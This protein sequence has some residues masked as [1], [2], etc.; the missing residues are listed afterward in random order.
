MK[1]AKEPSSGTKIL[2]TPKARGICYCCDKEMVAKCGEIKIHHWAHKNLEEC[3]HWWEN[4]T[5]WHRQWKDWFPLDWQEVV[6]RDA[7]SGEKHIADVYNP[8]KDLTI[9][10]QNSPIK[11]EEI[12]AREKYYK[13][14][15]W[16]LNGSE[17]SF[18]TMPIDGS[19]ADFAR[20]EARVKAKFR[21]IYREKKIEIEEQVRLVRK[22]SEVIEDQF[23]NKRITNIE[24]LEKSIRLDKQV[25]T[26]RKKLERKKEEA[27]SLAKKE[28]EFRDQYLSANSKREYGNRFVIYDWK[29]KSPSWS[30]ANNPIFVHYQNE[31]FLLKSTYIAVS[32]PLNTFLTKYGERLLK[33]DNP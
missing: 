3:D 8:I 28:L 30:C 31:L 20:L 19:N 18:S 7:N 32:V 11:G 27:V 25:A 2:A 24:W 4:E 33:R 29:Y 12:Q 16:L 1:F 26:L 5:P 9:E 21:K 13:R 17:L 15:L 6:K 23:T 22:E 14:M 10:F